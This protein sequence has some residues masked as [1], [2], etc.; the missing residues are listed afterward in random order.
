MTTAQ[1]IFLLF[2]VLYLVCKG[3]IFVV[4]YAI[5]LRVERKALQHKKQREQMIRVKRLRNLE[6]Y[7]R[8]YQEAEKRQ[9]QI[10]AL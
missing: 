10:R 7:Q 6:L 2:A 4:I 1:K 3:I 9:R 5:T 8:Q